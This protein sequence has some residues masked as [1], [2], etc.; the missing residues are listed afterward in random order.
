M[1]LDRF[2]PIVLNTP[3]TGNLE[4]T[5]KR[6][7]LA[8][9]VLRPFLA[10]FYSLNV[11]AG[12]SVLELIGAFFPMVLLLY[13]A[14]AKPQVSVNY[15]GGLY[16]LVILWVL[17]MTLL[18][19]SIYGFGGLQS[20]SSFFRV[21]NGFA[22]F[23]TFPLIFKDKKGINH[24]TTA[25]FIGTFFPLL[26][27][28]AQL[29]LGVDFGGMK[30]SVTAGQSSGD[31]EMYYGLYYKYGGYALAA[32]IGGLI[33]IYKIGVASKIKNRKL[34]IYLSFFILY[35]LLAA[36]TLSRVLVF[37]ML[38]IIIAIIITS[39]MGK[40]GFQKVIAI[41]TLSLLAFCLSG[42]GFVKDRYG[43]IVKR[44][45][46]EFA[47]VSGEANVESAFHGRVGHWEDKLE[48]FNE[49]PFFERLTGTNIGIGPHGDYVEWLLKY[50]YIGI[51][52]YCILF[53]GL[54]LSSIRMFFRITRIG[55]SYLQPYGIMVIAGL[56]IW[57]MEGV[58]HNSSQMPD[59]SYF[60]I[61]NTAIFLSLIQRGVEYQDEQKNYNI[62]GSYTSA[63]YGAEYCN[64]DNP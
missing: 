58:I 21:L 39:T 30:T 32:L 54:L 35:L 4:M 26:Q 14:M 46:N 33:M 9:I 22:V 45:E 20:F 28:I 3:S 63:V 16:L 6:L 36:L 1:V 60:I 17:L 56:I 52:L 62:Y 44:S 38:T 34:C 64:S 41:L 47:V 51:I 42:L 59:Y 55:N 7:I 40:S 48:Q 5:I 57:L 12:F 43:Q 18:K 15:Y 19:M 31:V 25:F 2:Y 61:G 10:V 24:L 29:L 8:Y 53:F 27:G 37:S 23:V 49:K 11:V 13:W 50:G